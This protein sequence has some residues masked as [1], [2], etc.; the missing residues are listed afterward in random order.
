MLPK[1]TE[2]KAVPPFLRRGGEMGNLI[3]SINWS[4]T[5]LGNPNTWPAAL[6]Y[7]VSMMLATNFPVLI[8]WGNDYIQLYNDAFRPVLGETKHPEAMGLASSKTFAEIW[9]TIEPFF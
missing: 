6:K 3:R 8:C 4:S 7:S 2:H 1:E 9:P 5:Q